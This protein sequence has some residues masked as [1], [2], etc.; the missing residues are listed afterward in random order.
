MAV[1]IATGQNR[2]G[3]PSG[4]KAMLKAAP[5][6][7]WEMIEAISRTFVADIFLQVASFN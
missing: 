5:A 7:A 3:G 2:T 4:A 6:A 1:A